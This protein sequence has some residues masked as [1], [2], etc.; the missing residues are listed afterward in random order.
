MTESRLR[1]WWRDSFSVRNELH[2]TAS[3]VFAFHSV[4]LLRVCTFVSE[5]SSKTPPDLLIWLNFLSLAALN[6]PVYRHLVLT[7]ASLIRLQLLP[8]HIQNFVYIFIHYKHNLTADLCQI[9]CIGQHRILLLRF[10][11]VHTHTQD[12]SRFCAAVTEQQ[13]GTGCSFEMWKLRKPT[14]QSASL[15]VCLSVYRRAAVCCT[16]SA[17]TTSFP[18][19]VFGR[20]SS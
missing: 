5:Y 6:A 13:S 19:V 20:P 11:Y 2:P 17:S 10:F 16:A 15:S 3:V 12:S 8:R 9:D 14:R 18:R 1:W 4:L 7:R